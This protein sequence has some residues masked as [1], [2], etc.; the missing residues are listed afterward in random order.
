V[1]Q[2]FPRSGIVA[3]SLP[4]IRRSIEHLAEQPSS[5]P[6]AELDLLTDGLD[7]WLE[8]LDKL[9]AVSEQSASIDRCRSPRATDANLLGFAIDNSGSEPYIAVRG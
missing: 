9:C 6:L 4:K 2:Q 8:G 3:V 5:T 1:L 7:V